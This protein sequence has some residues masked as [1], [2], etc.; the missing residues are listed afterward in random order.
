MTFSVIVPFLNEEEFVG[1]CVESLLGQDVDKNEYEIIFVDNGS[2]DKSRDILQQYP[3]IFL[4]IEKKLSSYA[5][6]NSGIKAAKADIIAFTDADCTVS[7]DWLT[8]INMGMEKTNASVVLGKRLFAPNRSHLLQMLT[9]YENAKV[10]YIS[11]M[12]LEAK[13]CFGFTNNMA[14][15][16]EVFQRIGPF[17]EVRRGGD[18]EFVQRY[19]S[20]D[21]N[22][23]LAYLPEMTIRHEEI[24][25]MVHWL[26]KQEVRGESNRR[27]SR[28]S[29]YKKL[30]LK[31][32]LKILSYSH[33]KHNY[34]LIDFVISFSSLLIGNVFYKIGEIRRKKGD[35][36]D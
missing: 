29:P 36:V 30:G 14:V 24:T 23:K 3:Q 28:Y 19:L 8:Q 31:T 25:N 35:V 6:R 9:D 7:K 5:A 26:K 20:S 15:K 27:V 18:T 21:G 33:R 10:E 17:L 2:T 12:P 4:L 16:A 11:E 32:K 13:Y 1:G 22:S 34:T